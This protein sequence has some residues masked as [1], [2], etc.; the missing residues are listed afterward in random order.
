[1]LYKIGDS[2]FLMG[3]VRNGYE[4]FHRVP[5]KSKP[6]GY[7]IKF[8]WHFS[9]LA[10][11]CQHLPELLLEQIN[12]AQKANK[13]MDA[14]VKDYEAAVNEVK[15]FAAAHLGDLIEMRKSLAAQA[16]EIGTKAG[17]S[18]EEIYPPKS[19]NSPKSDSLGPKLTGKKQPQAPKKKPK[20]T[21]QK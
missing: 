20:E 10:T 13:P 11:L 21:K 6:E 4:I 18:L 19:P 9:T 14:L 16:E 12:R 15:R 5:N 17:L 3:V 2:P 7:E 8:L 1:M